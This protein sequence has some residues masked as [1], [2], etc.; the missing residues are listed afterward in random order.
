[1]KRSERERMLV[2]EL[3]LASDPELV[4]LRREARRL[5]RLYNATRETEADE[6]RRIL[7]ELFGAIGE[8]AEVEPPFRCDYGKNIRAGAGLFMNFGCVVLDCGPVTIGDR[9]LIGPGVHIYGATHPVDAET[10]RTGR[11][12]GAPVLIGSDVWIGGGVIIGPGVSVGDGSVIGA[13]SVVM[14]SIPA[15]VVAAG[16]PC[17]V[18]RAIRPRD[19]AAPREGFGATKN[20]REGGGL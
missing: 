5:T 1:M 3:Y 19:A 11:E 20:P 14:R 16:N 12:Y 13:G 4:S 6:R 7:G 18:L 10:R 15:G 8:G 9:V 2:G 17:R